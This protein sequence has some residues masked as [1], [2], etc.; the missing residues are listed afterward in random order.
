M[1]LSFWRFDNKV[2]EPP[3]ATIDKDMGHRGRYKILARYSTE[4][5]PGVYLLLC[6]F[7][8]YISGVNHSLHQENTKL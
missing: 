2:Y 3:S 6:K 1:D 5:V 4:I 8:L 7:T